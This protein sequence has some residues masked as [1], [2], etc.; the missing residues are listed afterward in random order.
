MDEDEDW[1]EDTISQDKNFEELVEFEMEEKDVTMEVEPAQLFEREQE[2]V[3]LGLAVI[4]PKSYATPRKTQKH[5]NHELWGQAL[6]E[7]CF[8]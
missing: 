8:N 4:N 1:P 3:A 2:N 5:L 7:Q 6:F